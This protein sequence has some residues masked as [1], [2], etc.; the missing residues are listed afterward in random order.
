MEVGRSDGGYA[1]EKI[2]WYE[3]EAYAYDILAY[4]KAHGDAPILAVKNILGRPDLYFYMGLG[5]LIRQDMVTIREREG[6]FWAIRQPLGAT[7]N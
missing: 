7:A 5:E 3:I 2:M 6:I 4:L 1:M